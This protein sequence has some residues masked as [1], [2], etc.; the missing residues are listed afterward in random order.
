[1]IERF[2]YSSPIGY[3]KIDI[4]GN[5]VCLLEFATDD[6][7]QGSRAPI[8]NELFKDCANQLSAYFS[9]RLKTFSLPLLIKGTEFQKRVWNELTRIPYGATISYSDLAKKMGNPNSTRAVGAANGQNPIS[10]IIP[11]HRVIGKTGKLT[12]YG[13]G[14]P[15]KK[16]LLEHETL[17][18]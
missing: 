5:R 10:I 18:R 2:Y 3:L 11:C 6:E 14:M 13:G 9:G 12:G 7:Y 17:N 16:W 1:M 8:K 15:K 4:E